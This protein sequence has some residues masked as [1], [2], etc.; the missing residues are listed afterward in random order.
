[1]VEDTPDIVG[2]TIYALQ[3][4]DQE[5]DSTT[6]A[7]STDLSH[8]LTAQAFYAFEAV[9]RI[10]STQAEGFKCEF[11]GVGRLYATYIHRTST[12]HS[13]LRPGKCRWTPRWQ[14]LT[15]ALTK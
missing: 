9:L 1:V 2:A 13:R 4:A 10:S 6:I 12:G 15:W 3:N 5:N 11:T 14:S 8:S 7:L